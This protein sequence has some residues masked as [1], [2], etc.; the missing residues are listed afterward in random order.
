MS[1]KIQN[2]ATSLI[3]TDGQTQMRA[4][5]N[6]EKVRE[7]AEIVRECLEVAE[8]KT[9]VDANILDYLETPFP[10]VVLFYDGREYWVGAGHH[11][12]RAFEL[13]NIPVAPADVRDG[14]FREALFYATGGNKHGLPMS[15][16]DKRK[17]VTILLQD[18]EWS[19]Q[20]S[21]R[22]IAAHA[23]V[24]HEFV[25]QMA[26]KLKKG[27]PTEEAP[28]PAKEAKPPK[29]IAPP[30]LSTV[31]T[32]AEPAPSDDELTDDEWL[33]SLP[34]YLALKT[35]KHRGQ[36]VGQDALYYR[37]LQQRGTLEQLNRDVSRTLD[38]NDGSTPFRS[39]V[40]AF[41]RLPHPRDWKVCSGC[42]RSGCA[43]CQSAGYSMNSG[44]DP[45]E[46]LEKT[47]DD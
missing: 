27:E 43:R 18:E 29:E 17:A 42:R 35:A 21:L 32:P 12:I 1:K 8:E 15:T 47:H 16:A 5:L 33:N 3:R 24:S 10:P 41:V 14:G 44:T 13:N 4:S 34:I 40:V 30:R 19:Q 2:I 45:A 31:D 11:R 23:G 26:T 7:Y 25:R 37:T 22:E 28:K 46:F 9:P 20:M 6:Q 36:L 39:Q 38:V